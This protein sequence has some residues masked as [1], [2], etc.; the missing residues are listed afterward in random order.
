MCG[1]LLFLFPVII[2]G[3]EMNSLIQLNARDAEK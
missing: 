1:G 2:L 3:S